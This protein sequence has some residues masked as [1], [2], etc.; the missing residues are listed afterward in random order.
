MN[1]IGSAVTTGA[2]LAPMGRSGKAPRYYAWIDRWLA[3]RPFEGSPARLYSDAARPAFADLDERLLAHMAP[4]LDA[5]TYFIDV[6]AGTGVT[7][8][9]MAAAYPK[10]A[11]LAV[12]PS[13]TFSR[14]VLRGVARLR[15]YAEALPLATASID[16]ALCL[17]SLRHT[18]DRL[19]AL[20]EL[21]RVVRPTGCAWIVEL[22]PDATAERAQRHR[23]ALRS[24]LLRW[25]FD[26]YLLRTG[27]TGAM[28][29][30]LA[31]E[32]GFRKFQLEPDPLQPF[33]IL[34]L[35]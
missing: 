29:A 35:E 7:A 33:F 22:D 24:R 1:R 5:A 10:L 25:L 9:A 18:H 13:A 15:G 32:A 12:E 11:V 4:D 14:G 34:R 27:P 19:G 8:E 2:T 21:R 26:P 3:R 6:G 20:S 16:V 31:R 17:S 23:T 30:Q 28:F